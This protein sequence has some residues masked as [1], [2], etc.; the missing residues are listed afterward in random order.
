MGL[1]LYTPAQVAGVLML[2]RSRTYELLASGELPSVKI[3][4]SRRIPE[5]LLREYIARLCE[6]A[7][8]VS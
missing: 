7:A 6:R 2:S 4:R 1:Q 5:E 3:G 8:T